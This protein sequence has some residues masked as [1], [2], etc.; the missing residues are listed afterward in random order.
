MGETSSTIVNSCDTLVYSSSLRI[1]VNVHNT[2]EITKFKLPVQLIE[3]NN[4]RYFDRIRAN[5]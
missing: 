3:M 2:N 4:D 5:N 1:L